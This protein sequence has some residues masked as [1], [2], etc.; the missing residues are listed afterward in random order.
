MLAKQ[1]GRAWIV[2]QRKPHLGSIERSRASHFLL[3]VFV[4]L[5]EV[6]PLTPNLQPTNRNVCFPPI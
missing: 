3:G 5:R 2:L 4:S 1:L 6:P